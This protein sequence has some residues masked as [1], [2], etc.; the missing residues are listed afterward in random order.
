MVVFALDL[1]S[2][3]KVVNVDQE[4][5]AIRKEWVLLNK[6]KEDFYRKKK[7]WDGIEE[8]L[9]AG[10]S[11]LEA[12]KNQAKDEADRRD[13]FRKENKTLDATSQDLKNNIAVLEARKEDISKEES[14]LAKTL[15]NAQEKLRSIQAQNLSLVRA[16]Q[17][18]E[19]KSKELEHHNAT[20]E[21]E[22][23]VNEGLENAIKD[24]VVYVDMLK[25]QTDKMAAANANESLDSS[26]QQSDQSSVTTLQ[27]NATK[28]LTLAQTLQ[29]A[30]NDILARTGRAGNSDEN[31][32]TDSMTGSS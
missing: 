14:E 12:V 32:S 10:S 26:G 3:S 22:A 25:A 21:Q 30:L 5:V 19:N 13:Q 24:F 27:D 16:N 8:R 1:V 2:G 23:M 20:L 15:D 11:K 4:R 31:Q 17:D 6:E 9:T 7:E 29:A 28:L 18:L